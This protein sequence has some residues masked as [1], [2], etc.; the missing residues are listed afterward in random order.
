MTT[1][2]LPKM[3]QG[4]IGEQTWRHQDLVQEV[5]ATCR[6]LSKDISQAI[7]TSLHLASLEL[8]ALTEGQEVRALI[9]L[10]WV[11]R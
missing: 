2:L 4:P 8:S 5:T 6:T 10:A 3:G 1:L 9:L 11:S 7:T